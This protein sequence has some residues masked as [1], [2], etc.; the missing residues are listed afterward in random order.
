MASTTGGHE[1]ESP[2]IFGW[3]TEQ[4]AYREKVLSFAREHLNNAVLERDHEALFDH[5][6]WRRCAEF[7]IHA[8][9]MPPEVGGTGDD[10]LTAMLA[11]E[12]LGIGCEDN[13][14]TL[15]LN[16]QIWTVQKPIVQFGTP[17]QQARFLPS[18]CRGEMI[19]A[20]AI[21][22]PNSGSDLFS[23][24]TTAE[25]QG[26]HY[27]LNG[28]KKFIT[29]APIADLALVFATVDPSKGRWGVT[30]FLVEKNSPGYR[31]EATCDKMGVR[32]VPMGN[33]ILEDCLV[34]AANRLGPECA[35]AS[36]SSSSLEWERTF[37]LASQLGAMER[38]L[39]R[40]VRYARERRQF[41]KPI[42]SFQSVSNRIADMK[43]RL[44]AARL[45]LYRVA[46]LKQVGKN[47]MLEAAVTKLF[48]SESYVESSEDAIR[49]HGGNGYMKGFGVERD[50]RDA[51]GSVIYGGTSDIQRNVIAR[52]LGL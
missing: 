9:G 14:L 19:G 27:R 6:G 42:G 3:T 20:H 28:T 8:L 4:A 1:T 43:V 7:G 36:I 22:E 11:M 45:L 35:G 12:A 2:G 17:D 38:Q 34:P 18:M 5:E 16:A 32:T 13:G 47:A 39:E 48:I 30:G 26:D 46:S 33:I 37:I 21:T 51:M 49:V 52:L 10:I 25:K 31:V 15:A 24:S 23:L 41:G 50:L 40:T 44:D 29:L